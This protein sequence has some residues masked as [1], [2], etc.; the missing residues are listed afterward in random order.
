MPLTAKIGTITKGKPQLQSSKT[1]N[2]KFT[3]FGIKEVKPYGAAEGWEPRFYN[4][5]AF[6]EMAE[7]ICRDFDKGDRVLVIG[8]GERREY[9]KNDGSPGVSND[10]TA[11]GFG[12]DVRF[13]GVDI[14]R[15]VRGETRQ[16]SQAVQVEYAEDEEEF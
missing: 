5:T 10:I 11:D 9:T 13:C 6:G 1:G 4:V 16:P 15:Q 2:T 3:K 14:H 7:R 8:N 12:P